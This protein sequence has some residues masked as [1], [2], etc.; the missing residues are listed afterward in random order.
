MM[1]KKSYIAKSGDCLLCP[2]APTAFAK[3]ARDFFAAW[4]ERAVPIFRPVHTF[5]RVGRTLLH[6]SRTP[7]YL[8]QNGILI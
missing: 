3:A 1:L 8:M 4:T 6:D 5:V 7:R 2:K